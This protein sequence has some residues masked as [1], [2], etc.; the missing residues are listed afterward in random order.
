MVNRTSFSA[1]K[2]HSLR[3][4]P[5]MCHVT[6]PPPP[7]LSSRSGY[8]FIK[9]S[10]RFPTEK[11]Q[12]STVSYIEQLLCGMPHLQMFN[13]Q[14]QSMLLSKSFSNPILKY[15][16]STILLCFLFCSSFIDFFLYLRFFLSPFFFY[17]FLFLFCLLC[18]ILLIYRNAARQVLVYFFCNPV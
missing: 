14:P 11:P 6:P 17:S 1:R 7:P 5:S 2:T 15:K 9:P 18:S 10:Y 12:L 3:L 16:P 4:K 8:T 13:K